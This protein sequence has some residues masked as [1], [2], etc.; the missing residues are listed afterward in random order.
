M[1]FTP[2]SERL[3]VERSNHL[4]YR[5]SQNLLENALENVENISMYAVCTCQYKLWSFTYRLVEGEV[6]PRERE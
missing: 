5:L 2:V 4:F 3:P 6:S 1:T